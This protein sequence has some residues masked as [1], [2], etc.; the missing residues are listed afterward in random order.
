[1]VVHVLLSRAWNLIN[2]PVCRGCAP[3]EPACLPA[4]PPTPPSPAQPAQL[5]E[6][7]LAPCCACCACC[8]GTIASWVKEMAAYVKGLDSY[9]L[10]TVGEEGFASTTRQG[11]RLPVPA[12]ACPHLPAC[13][14]ERAADMP[15]CLLAR[16]PSDT[17]TRLPLSPPLVLAVAC[18]ALPA[19]AAHSSAHHPSIHPSNR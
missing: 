4:C 13:L 5:A 2:E 19:L 3:G 16:Q 6:C 12:C 10:L 15:R 17:H 18:P 8:A 1:M 7:N 11:A 14:P 9:H